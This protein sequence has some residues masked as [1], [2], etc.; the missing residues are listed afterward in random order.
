MTDSILQRVSF[1]TK[2][3]GDMQNDNSQKMFMAFMAS[4]SSAHGNKIIGGAL[5]S[6]ANKLG[7]SSDRSEPRNEKS[8]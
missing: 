5:S 4:K 2:P 8:K 1:G 6:A 7:L 3:L